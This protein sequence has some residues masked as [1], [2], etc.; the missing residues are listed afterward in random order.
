MQVLLLCLFYIFKWWIFIKFSLQ[1]SFTAMSTIPGC[2]KVIT[3][4]ATTLKGNLPEVLYLR[5]DKYIYKFFIISLS[6]TQGTQCVQTY[7][8]WIVLSWTLA[9]RLICKPLRTKYP[10]LMSLLEAGK[11]WKIKNCYSLWSLYLIA[12]L[13]RTVGAAWAIRTREKSWKRSPLDRAG[14]VHHPLETIPQ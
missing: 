12:I 13:H 1:R 6:I 9:F 2:S 10:T 8:R 5:K 3:I 11:V 14:L 4:F 7:S